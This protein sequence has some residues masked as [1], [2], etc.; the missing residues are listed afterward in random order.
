MGHRRGEVVRTQTTVLPMHTRH[1]LGSFGGRGNGD[2]RGE[3]QAALQAVTTSLTACEL[4]VPGWYC[5][6]RWAIRR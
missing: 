2:D 4:P 5:P 6:H 1:W 3:L